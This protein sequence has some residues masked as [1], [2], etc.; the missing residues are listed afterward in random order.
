[1]S[2]VWA[3]VF[4]KIRKNHIKQLLDS[5]LL[6]VT[7]DKKEGVMNKQAKKSLES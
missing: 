7:L 4:Y 1:M 5:F 2:G 6:F 3:L